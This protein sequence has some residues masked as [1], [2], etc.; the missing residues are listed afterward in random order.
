[1]KYFIFLL[2]TCA[3]YARMITPVFSGEAVNIRLQAGTNNSALH[4]ETLPYRD[5]SGQV[6]CPFIGSFYTDT[7]EYGGCPEINVY[8]LAKVAISQDNSLDCSYEFNM[9][10]SFMINVYDQRECPDA[11]FSRNGFKFEK[12]VYYDHTDRHDFFFPDRQPFHTQFVGNFDQ[13]RKVR[14]QRT[15]HNRYIAKGDIMQ[16]W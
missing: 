7:T 6:I 15:Y 4:L 11:I 9:D 13:V 10:G 5:R 12:M 8:R 2:L 3:V 1:M 14:E 16:P